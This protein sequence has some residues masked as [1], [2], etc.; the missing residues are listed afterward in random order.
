MEKNEELIR[1]YIGDKNEEMYDK[2]MKGRGFN[3]GAFFLRG[4]YMMNR[5]MYFYGII[6]SI[7]DFILLYLI[8]VPIGIFIF[9]IIVGCG[10]YQQ[11][12]SHIIR[13]IKKYADL[14]Y[15]EQLK[16]AELYG[17]NKLTVASTVIMT[18]V[19]LCFGFGIYAMT[20][21]KLK[22]NVP[23][24]TFKSQKSTTS[25]SDMVTF[26]GDGY[27]LKY[28]TNIWQPRDLVDGDGQMLMHKSTLNTISGKF[29]EKRTI[30]GYVSFEETINNYYNEFRDSYDV[31]AKEIYG[32]STTIK[33]ANEIVKK[34]NNVYLAQFN[35][36]FDDKN[37]DCYMYFKCNELDNDFAVY[38]VANNIMESNNSEFESELQ[39][40]LDTIEF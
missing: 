40:L 27:K 19:I 20:Q 34:D 22:N 39:E 17:G 3:W 14:P 18:I 9:S 26:F 37:L 30:S 32:K 29:I 15:E 21:S 1:K 10:F 24:K 25:S 23:N 35:V 11:Y 7:I 8:K 6:V 2:V 28:N 36:K 38:V 33:R 4:L 5:K 31:L 13:K 12:K 16:K